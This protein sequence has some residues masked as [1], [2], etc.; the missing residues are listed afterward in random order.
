LG[1]LGRVVRYQVN[2]N[3]AT[4]HPIVPQVRMKAKSRSCS[5]SLSPF[6]LRWWNTIE[7]VMPSVGAKNSDQIHIH[8]I[9]PPMFGCCAI[10][11]AATVQTA[12]AIP[13]KPGSA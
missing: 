7:F 3:P 2:R 8:R 13:R 1:T 9:S 10:I 5:A 12:A 4:I 6:W 11:H